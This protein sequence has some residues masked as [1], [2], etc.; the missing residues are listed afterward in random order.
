MVGADLARDETLELENAARK[1]AAT[2][3]RIAMPLVEIG[4]GDAPQGQR[5]PF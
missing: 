2:S 1:S 3:E 5:G 4:S